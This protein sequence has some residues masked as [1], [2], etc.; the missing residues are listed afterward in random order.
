MKRVKQFKNYIQISLRF[1]SKFFKNLNTEKLI[2][3]FLTEKKSAEWLILNWLLI[4]STV[5]INIYIAKYIQFDK[6]STNRFSLIIFH[7]VFSNWFCSHSGG[8]TFK[9]ETYQ[10]ILVNSWKVWIWKRNSLRL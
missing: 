9:L 5:Y 2:W 3:K 6:Y 1:H 4:M 8:H 10:D 7:V